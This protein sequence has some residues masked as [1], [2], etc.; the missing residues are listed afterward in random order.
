MIISQIKEFCGEHNVSYVYSIEVGED[1]YFCV[2]N[3]DTNLYTFYKIVK[4]V[5]EI[6]ED[7]LSL[8]NAKFKK[9]VLL[10][11]GGTLLER[12]D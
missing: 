2:L 3:S 12:E 5:F 8:V 4:G 6:Y 10:E 11:M 9:N 7:N 1:L